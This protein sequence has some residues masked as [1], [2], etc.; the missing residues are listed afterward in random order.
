MAPEKLSRDTVCEHALALA[1]RE[2]LE[3]VTIRRLAKELGVTPMALYWHFKNK[4]ELLNALTEHALRHVTANL[5]PDDPWDVR[6]HAIVDTVLT[7]MRAHPCLPALLGVADKHKVESFQRATEASLG[8]LGEAGFPMR[9]RYWIATYLLNGCIA[10]VQNNPA[11]PDLTA[12]ELAEHRRLRRLEIE[13]LP[14]DRFP[15]TI[16]YARTMAEPA[17]PEDFFA[18]GVELLISGVRAIAPQP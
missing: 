10:L 8:V 12:Q 3:A 18:F 2:G 7:A 1:D 13:S 4:D 5:S 9:R 6:L 11:P 17:D 14:A 15:C 16:A